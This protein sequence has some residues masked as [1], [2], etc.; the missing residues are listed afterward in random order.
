MKSPRM[1]IATL[2]VLL[3][4]LVCLSGCADAPSVP[5]PS[6]SISESEILEMNA[7]ETLEGAS[8]GDDLETVSSMGSLMPPNQQN[9]RIVGR[10]LDVL[11]PEKFLTGDF[12]IQRIWVPVRLSVEQGEPD[13]SA[14][15]MT[16]R[17]FP[18]SE[19]SPDFRL[20][21]KGMRVLA[22]GRREDVD[23]AGQSGITLGWF[24]EITDSGDVRR[25]TPE[26]DVLGKFNDY[27]EKLSLT[28]LN[29]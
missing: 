7:I 24:F 28:D 5:D 16:V 10:I 13:L 23:Q 21:K 8:V 29:P 2:P 1:K 4:T 20:L 12:G 19:L 6:L 11:P 14:K 18:S 26:G 22:V 9:V 3:V 17:L 27:A 25:V 15:M